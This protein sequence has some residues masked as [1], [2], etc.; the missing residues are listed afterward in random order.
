MKNRQ[1]AILYASLFLLTTVTFGNISA[2]KK[3]QEKTE[4]KK[5]EQSSGLKQKKTEKKK[6]EQSP[7]L[8]QTG[9]KQLIRSKQRPDK[10]N[11]SNLTI[12]LWLTGFGAAIVLCPQDYKILGLAGMVMGALMG[13]KIIKVIN[14]HKNST[15]HAKNS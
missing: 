7:G 10:Q 12:G 6:R 9:L 4:K 5:R 11:N 13:P 1:R 14:K 3:K 15:G 2:M 8:K